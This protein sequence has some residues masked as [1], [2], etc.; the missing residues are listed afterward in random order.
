M[1]VSHLTGVLQGVWSDGKIDRSGDN[2]SL[3]G[4]EIKQVPHSSTRRTSAFDNETFQLKTFCNNFYDE[5]S[6]KNI[7]N[8]I[9][10]YSIIQSI[11]VF[12]TLFIL[13]AVHD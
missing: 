8:R 2:F 7:V 9:P 4:L 12:V 1:N 11:N 3:L 13:P 10:Q 5:C 6:C